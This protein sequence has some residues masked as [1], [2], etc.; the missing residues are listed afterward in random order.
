MR[1]HDPCPKD[2]A[3][4]MRNVALALPPIC[5]WARKMIA[6]PSS[7][8]LTVSSKTLDAP[9][10]VKGNSIEDSLPAL[11]MCLTEI[12]EDQP[13][14]QQKGLAELTSHRSVKSVSHISNVALRKGT[15]VWVNC[16]GEAVLTLICVGV[17]SSRRSKQTEPNG[18]PFNGPS[19]LAFAKQ[20][21]AVTE[22]VGHYRNAK[23]DGSVYLTDE[24]SKTYNRR[25]CARRLQTLQS[26]T[27]CF[28]WLPAAGFRRRHRT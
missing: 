25:I 7:A 20:S 15:L 24:S 11:L 1:C 6:L 12:E 4:L 18:L 2:I 10:T 21:T 8:C 23:L 17:R 19:V 14:K 28:G 13:H 22:V 26:P 16:K 9:S 27:R 5:S 3:Y